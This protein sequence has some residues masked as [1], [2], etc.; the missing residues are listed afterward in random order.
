M[1]STDRPAQ[2]R[3]S[4]RTE[5]L[6]AR[7]VNLD[8][9]IDEWPEVGLVAMESTWRPE[10][11]PAA[12]GR[13]R[14]WRWTETTKDDFDFLDQFIAERAIDIAVAEEA[15]ALPRRRDRRRL[16]VDPRCLAPKCCASPAG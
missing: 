1:T 13:L 15:M 10:A 6:E 16:V 14:S 8:G 5:I 2:N 9:F 12:S 11:E 7:A 3:H 4:R